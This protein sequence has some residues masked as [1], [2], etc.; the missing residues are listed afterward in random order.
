MFT[1]FG[2]FSMRSSTTFSPFANFLRQR[3]VI[4][5]NLDFSRNPWPPYPLPVSVPFTASFYSAEDCAKMKRLISFQFFFRFNFV[6]LK[7]SKYYSSFHMPIFCR[8][9]PTTKLVPSRQCLYGKDY[10]NGKGNASFYFWIC[11]PF[12]KRWFNFQKMSTTRIKVNIVLNVV[13][14]LN[15]LRLCGFYQKMMTCWHSPWFRHTLQV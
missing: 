15:E 5:H 12:N 14:L 6:W 10:G 9:A 13:L 4:R 2:I 8:F 3:R 1:V 7:T 11:E